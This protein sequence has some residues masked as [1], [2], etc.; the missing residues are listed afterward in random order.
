MV[1]VKHVGKTKP[2][3][4]QFTGKIKQSDLGQVH[5]N[6]SLPK[7]ARRIFLCTFS[8]YCADFGIPHDLK[9][10]MHYVGHKANLTLSVTGNWKILKHNDWNYSLGC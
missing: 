10:P 2:T 1:L 3:V 4:M 7:K 8:F 6:Q 9:I 5:R